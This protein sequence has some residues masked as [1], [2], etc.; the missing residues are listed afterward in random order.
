MTNL[1][2]KRPF[3]SPIITP[4]TTLPLL[5]HLDTPHQF[6]NTV[7]TYFIPTTIKLTNP[8]HPPQSWTPSL[9]QIIQ[10]I[11][12]AYY[13]NRPTIKIQVTFFY[14]TTCMSYNNRIDVD[15]AK[16]T[17]STC[18]INPYLISETSSYD[19]F[20]PGRSMCKCLTTKTQHLISLLINIYNIVNSL[21][22]KFK[23]SY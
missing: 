5:M 6:T 20:P 10:C 4:K 23:T 17:T 9:V 15:G 2:M 3:S 8:T 16:I 11:T 22:R 7:A 19:L 1:S 21:L 12:F 14:T 13:S 18:T